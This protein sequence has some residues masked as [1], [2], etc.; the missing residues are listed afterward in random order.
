MGHPVRIKCLSNGLLGKLI[1]VS[2][3]GN[4]IGIVSSNLGQACLHFPSH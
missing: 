2:V 4:G 3:V 1:S